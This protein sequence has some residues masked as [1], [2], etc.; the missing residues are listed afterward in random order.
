[1]EDLK[2]FKFGLLTSIE[3]IKGYKRTSDSRPIN[4]WRCVCDCGNV[5]YI[6]G[7]VLVKNQRVS[8]GCAKSLNGLKIGDTFT[9]PYGQYTIVERRDNRWYIVKFT[10]GYTCESDYKTIKEG[11]VRNPYTPFVCGV[12][13]FG[14]GSFKCKIGNS[15]TIQ[16][17]V[18]N[19]LFKRCYNLTRQQTKRPTYA[20]CLVAPEWHNYQNFAAWYTTQP[21]F[22]KGYHLDKDLTILGNKLYS[23]NT[24]YLIPEEVNSLLTGYNSKTEYP[25]GVH[26]CKTKNKFISQCN[27]GEYT[28]SGTKKQTYLGAFDT[29]EQAS[30]AYKIRKSSR[31]LEVAEKFKS[32]ISE[33]IY[34]NLKYLAEKL[35][36]ETTLEYQR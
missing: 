21:N 35:L 1:M 31:I 16:Y 28:K 8:C 36:E 29:A 14:E 26:W 24:C 9:S 20:G 2:G 33:P 7:C 13:F 34:K 30:I 17:E 22:G 4:V 11:K 27:T 15:N 19:G 12:G 32:E 3:H 10:D 23:P 6:Q 25:T 18:W 5:R